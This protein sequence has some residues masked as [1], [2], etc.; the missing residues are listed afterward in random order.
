MATKTPIDAGLIA[1]VANNIRT[2]LTNVWFGPLEPMTPMVSDAQKESVTGR[3]FDFPVG[4]N[5]NTRPRTGDQI[6]FDQLRGL[7]D[8]CDILRIVIE[9]R[10]DQMSKLKWSVRPK[11]DSLQP[12]DRCDEAMARFEFP[13]L[14][15]DWDTW[16]RMVME[17]LFVIDAATV[18]VRRN[19][20]GGL[21][22]LEPMD[23]ATI[24]RIIDDHGRT[25]A[26][27][28]PAYQQILKGLPAIDYTTEELIYR[29]RNVRT[30]RIYGYSPVE[31]IIMTVNTALR[32]SIHKLQFYTE[33]NIPEAIVG[34][35]VEWNPDQIAMFQKHWDSLNEGNTAERRHMKFVPGKL[36]IVMTKEEVLK[37]AFDEWLARVVCFAFSIE[38]T[39]FIHQNN[40]AT[41]ESA[42]EAA[43]SEGLA[44]I[45]QWVQNL[46]NYILWNVI[47][48]KDLKFDWVDEE[49]QDPLQRAQVNQIYLS[50]GVIL[51]DEVRE[52]LGMDPLTKE[53]IAEI[54]AAKQPP[55]LG[56]MPQDGAEVQGQQQ[57][58]APVVKVY[59]GDTLVDI[60][61]TT[62]NARFDPP[63]MGDTLVDIGDTTITAKF[64]K[65]TVAPTVRKSITARRQPD[66]SIIGEITEVPDESEIKTIVQKN[67]AEVL[68]VTPTILKG[69]E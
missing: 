53:Q 40:R 46:M 43:L 28:N 60:G 37:D 59:L 4:V 51:P 10:K 29:P 32:R 22:S 17:D 30:N 48:Y 68:I 35:P 16:L 14:E 1:R 25:P 42:R 8:N 12:D 38:P 15:H 2:A 33:G 36:D 64:D 63:V 26:L 34:T 55:I 24:K 56:Q 54:Q 7:A 5:R 62:I 13:D 18:Y 19:N 39:P 69:R 45:M 9:T 27:P 31:Q 23:G 47:G 65:P 52:D 50:T 6:T 61:D 66:G 67:T 21:Y 11:D 3:Q 20:G 57:K 49:V 58:G 44:P 41:A